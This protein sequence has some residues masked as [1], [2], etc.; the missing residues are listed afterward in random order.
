[1][2]IRSKWVTM[3]QKSTSLAHNDIENTQILTQ[4]LE[5]NTVSTHSLKKVCLYSNMRSHFLRLLC[6]W[7]SV[8]R[9]ERCTLFQIVGVREAEGRFPLSHGKWQDHPHLRRDNKWR[10]SLIVPTHQPDTE[11]VGPAVLF[12]EPY[13]LRKTGRTQRVKRVQN[14]H[15]EASPMA[16]SSTLPIFFS[17][18]LAFLQ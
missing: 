5:I 2:N 11:L 18:S 6:P 16:R 14:Q 12:T 7:G 15:R 3:L 4:N 9:G 8:E 10:N 1:M 17:L 13:F